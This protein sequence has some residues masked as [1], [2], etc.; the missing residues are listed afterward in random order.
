MTYP[1]AP[2]IYLIRNSATGKVYVGS[3]RSLYRRIYEHRRLLRNGGHGNSVLQASWASH[4]EEAFSFEVLE[5]AKDGSDECLLPM[6]QKHLDAARESGDV[7]NL[8]PITGTRRGAR[9]P[10]EAVAS[11]AALKRGN[12]YRK[13]AV[14]PQEMRDRIAEKLKG[15]KASEETKAKL[16]EIRRGRPKSEEWKRMMSEKFKGRQQKPHTPEQRAKIGP[17]T[18]AAI[19]ARRASREAVQDAD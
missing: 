17:A 5:L 18:R 12:K 3:A 4:G 10:P 19:A 15:R 9:M 16:S 1:K 8:C 14:I 7:Y 2:G 11:I 13:G 6:E